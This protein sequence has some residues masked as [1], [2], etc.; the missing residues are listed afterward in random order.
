[1]RKQVYDIELRINRNLFWLSVFVTLLSLTMMLVEFFTRGD[2]PATRIGLFYIG[3]LFIYSMHKEALRWIGGK[4]IQKG[5]R[6][7]EYFLYVW[8]VVTS[9]LYLINFLMKDYFVF[10]DM[11]NEL[12]ALSEITVTALEACGVFI[13]ARTAK[14]I[15]SVMYFRNGK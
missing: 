7:G 8:I 3:V 1:M 11:G 14:V 10:G 4:K 2:F 5:E 13:F 9:F 15:F 6:K 12:T